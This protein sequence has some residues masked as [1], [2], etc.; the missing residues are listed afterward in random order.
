MVCSKA[1]NVTLTV[2]L[3]THWYIGV[4]DQVCGQD[5]LISAK[6]FFFMDRDRVKVHKQI[7]PTRVANHNAGFG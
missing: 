3:S 2:P 1:K 4:I 6:F 5:A 7:L